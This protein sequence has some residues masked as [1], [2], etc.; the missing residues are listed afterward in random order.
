[1]EI[2]VEEKNKKNAQILKSLYTSKFSDLTMFLL[3]KYEN[4]IFIEKDSYFSKNMNKLSKDCLIH[5]EI[6]G[7]IIALLGGAPDHIDFKVEDVF[8]SNDKTK[9][10]E[11]NIRLTKE[12]IILYTKALNE[13]EDKYIKEILTKFILEE[14]TNLEILELI[15]LK[16]KKESSK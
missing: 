14:R 8:Y 15:Q 11:I 12:K 4:Y 1:M 7:R 2:K 16:N 5:F 3:Y 13:I 6:I 9:L 10:I